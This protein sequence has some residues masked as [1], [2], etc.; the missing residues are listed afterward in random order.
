MGHKEIFMR[1]HRIDPG[2][3]SDRGIPVDSQPF[4]RVTS[5]DGQ[6]LLNKVFT[7][8][9]PLHRHLRACPEDLLRIVDTDFL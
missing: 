3:G 7:P 5:I 6:M 9:E 1:C 8:R 2:N 4:L